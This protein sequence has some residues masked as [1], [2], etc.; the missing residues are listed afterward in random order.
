MGQAWFVGQSLIFSIGGSSGVVV[1]LMT[2]TMETMERMVTTLA[3]GIVVIPSNG[4]TNLFISP[5]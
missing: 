1:W 4:S 5:K 2:M 3:A